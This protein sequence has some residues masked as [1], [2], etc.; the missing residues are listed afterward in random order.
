VAGAA[1][2]VACA[3]GAVFVIAKL[4]TGRGGDTPIRAA[5]YEQPLVALMGLA[6]L[7]MGLCVA[8]YPQEFAS[9][10]RWSNPLWVWH[11]RRGEAALIAISTILSLG[12]LEI[13]SRALYARDEKLPFFFGPE[14]LVYPPLYHAMRDYDPA[15]RNVLVLGGSVMNGAGRGGKLEATL[16]PPWRVYN[17]AQN[18]QCSL[19]SLTKYRWLSEHGYRFD[20]VLLYEAIN[21]TRLNNVPSNVFKPDYSHYLFYRLV[22]AVFGNEHPIHRAA[23]H[24]ALMFR[25]DRLITQLRETRAF[26]QHF[27]NIAYP[28]EDWLGQGAL[29]KTE[30]PYEKNIVAIAELAK[31]SG[32][33]LIAAEFAYD[34]VLDPVENA[35]YFEG[36]P[37]YHFYTKEWGLPR[38]VRLGILTHNYV[39]RRHAREFQVIATDSFR[40]SENFIDPCHFTPDAEARFIH[41]WAEALRSH[42]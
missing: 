41:F 12:F 3:S 14:Y 18:A 7:A 27:V 20:Y 17:L 21:E 9:A 40:R 10:R 24:S 28:R 4:Y 25:A 29:I 36:P 8:I 13:G 22:H 23:L 15:A 31:R 1:S 35:T 6:G 39:L 37:D 30:A 19:D 2:A 32:A 38:N 42:S 34:P 16:G 5:I 33:K 26:G 11:A